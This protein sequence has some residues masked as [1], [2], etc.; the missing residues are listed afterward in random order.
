MTN[1][2]V[3]LVYGKVVGKLLAGIIDSPDVGEVPDFPPLEGRVIFSAAVPK[4]LVPLAEPP[5]TVVPLSN[6]LYTCVLDDEGFLTWRGKRGVYLAAPVA[7]TMNP[8]G[9]TWMVSFDLEYLGDPVPMASFAIDVPAY[10]AGPDEEDPDTGSVGLVDLTMVSPVP[11]SAGSAVVR[12]VS[13]DSVALDDN[14]LIF[15]LDDGTSLPGVTVPAIEDA[16]TAAT[17]AAASAA[18]AAASATDAQDAVDSFDLDVG[19]VTTGAAGSSASATVTGGPAYLVN[20]T[21]PRGD[22]GAA[23]PPAPDA[24]ASVKGIMR[25]TG[26]LGGDATTPTVPGKVDKF[27]VTAVKTTTYTAAVA[28][29]IPADASGGA[30]TITLPAAPADKSRIFIKKIDT[31]ATAVTIARGGSDVFEKTSGATSLTLALQ[32]QSVLL[33]YNSS[34]A[35]W[36]ASYDLALPALDTRFSAL[37]LA[38]AVK[39]GAYTAVAGDYVP[40][41]ATSAGFAVT[42]PT[43]P[44]D[45]TSVTVKKTD[46]SANT[47]TVTRG[48]S[49]VFNASGG[50]TTYALTRQNQGVRLVYKASGA[51]WYVLDHISNADARLSDTRTPS[52]GTQFYDMSITGFAKGTTRAAGTGDFPF[53]V[54]LQRAATFTSVTYR[55]TTADAS[56]N[57]VVKLQKNGS[58]TGMSGSSTTIAAANQITGGTGTGTWSF[59]AGDILTVVIVSVGTTPGLGLIADITGLA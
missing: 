30:F 55:A 36:Y 56:G 39:T 5:A 7:G 49:D 23:G 14:D 18:A 33:T 21:I 25:L 12:G 2:L 4:F 8:T 27:A 31:S 20:Y 15:G 16:T 41:D 51:I 58:D 57:L 6:D 34:A 50:A 24:T 54:K 38:T 28:D 19:T 47:V 43:A 17:A 52:T 37:M 26:D 22:T 44:A 11:S 13:V 45:G 53:G 3:P 40:A 42:L 29:L 1:P 32:F 46:S 35:V 10:V 9:W 48:G 59:A